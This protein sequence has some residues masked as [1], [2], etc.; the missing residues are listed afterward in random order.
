MSLH[1]PCYGQLCQ[2]FTLIDVKASLSHQV[3]VARQKEVDRLRDDLI[4]TFLVT[5]MNKWVI[6]CLLS[7]WTLLLGS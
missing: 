5:Q 4:S 6:S 7:R 3:G 1:E 2:L